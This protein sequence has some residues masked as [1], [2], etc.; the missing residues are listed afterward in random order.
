[1]EESLLEELLLK[2]ERT[3]ASIRAKVEH[4]FYVIKNLFGYRKMRYKGLTKNQVQ[5]FS[6]FGLAN[7]VL[8]TRCEERGDG[9]SSSCIWLGSRITRLPS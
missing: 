9:G 2:N 8:A 3:K 5:I 6:L 4:P 7:R 1:M